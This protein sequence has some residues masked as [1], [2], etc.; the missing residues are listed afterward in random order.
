MKIIVAVDKNWAIGNNGD[1][2]FRITDDLKRFR[3]M[4]TGNVIITGRKTLETFPNKKPLLNRIN[5]VLTSNEN[6]KN[7]D[8]IICKSIDDVIINIKE[9][10]DKDIFVVGGGSVYNQ[11]IDLCDTAYITKIDYAVEN[12]DT[13]M[14]NLDE[15]EDW[16][17]TE[18]SDTFYDD[19]ISFRYITYKRNL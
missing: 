15:R 4:T 6:Y 8:A 11:M 18:V 1:L 10:K 3:E 19:N 7:E 9:Y 5:I 17:I 12:A 14:I 16:F 13:F 2:L